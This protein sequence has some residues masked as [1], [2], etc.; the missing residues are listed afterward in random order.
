MFCSKLKTILKFRFKLHIAPE[1]CYCVVPENIHTSLGRGQIMRVLFSGI[2]Y[3]I[4][5][6][7]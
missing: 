4:V 1:N 7:R 6:Q 3:D 5:T 2:T